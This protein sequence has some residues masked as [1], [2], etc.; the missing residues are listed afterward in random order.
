MHRPVQGFPRL[1]LANPHDVAGTA[2]GGSD[3]ARLIADRAR[4]LGSSAVNAEIMGHG[5]FLAQKSSRFS[6][7]S[8]SSD[9][10][11]VSELWLVAIAP[12]TYDPAETVVRKLL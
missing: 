11:A 7:F 1:R 4:G 10:S 8:M 2:G 3:Q 5:L 6:R 9:P 12:D